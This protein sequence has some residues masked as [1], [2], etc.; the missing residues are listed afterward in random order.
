MNY[1]VTSSKKKNRTGLIV[2]VVLWFIFLA[3]TIFSTANHPL[4]RVLTILGAVYSLIRAAVRYEAMSTPRVVIQIDADGI[5]NR[6]HPLALGKIP[7]EAI[8]NVKLRRRGN[9]AVVCLYG[10]GMKALVR[11]KNIVQ[12]LG[13]TINQLFGF[14]WDRLVCLYADADPDEVMQALARLRK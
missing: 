14:G 13:I 7:W 3:L 6:S 12:R 2:S 11:H 5:I 8:E 4:M 10:K 9:Q 1:E